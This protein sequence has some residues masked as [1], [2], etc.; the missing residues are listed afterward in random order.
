MCTSDAT[1]GGAVAGK[2][3]EV[4]GPEPLSPTWAAGTIAQARTGTAAPTRGATMT[5]IELRQRSEK[6]W[7]D[8][9]SLSRDL[10]VCNRPHTTTCHHRYSDGANK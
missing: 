10:I 5:H 4:A 3:A 6:F 2:V 8:D 9:T 7:V 1:G